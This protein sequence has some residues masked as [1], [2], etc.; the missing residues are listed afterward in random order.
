MP[1]FTVHVSENVLDGAEAGLIGGLTDALV[2]VF[3]ERARP[4]T[5]PPSR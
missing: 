4:L 3:G 1:H 5:R 2:D